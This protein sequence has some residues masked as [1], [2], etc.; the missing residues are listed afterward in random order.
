MPDKHREWVVETPLP[1]A[2]TP[3]AAP[4][5]RKSSDVNRT[6][7]TKE[8]SHALASADHAVGG[9][10]VGNVRK[11]L[12]MLK[13]GKKSSKGSGLMGSLDEE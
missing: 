12:S 13:L 10:V 4:V 8:N 6:L 1:R 7:S 3:A 9:R 2:T 5:R 11:R